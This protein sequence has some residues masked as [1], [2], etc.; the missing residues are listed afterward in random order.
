MLRVHQQRREGLLRMN[1][2]DL[3]TVRRLEADTESPSFVR[4]LV[5]TYERMLSPRVER[6][7]DAV[8]ASDAEQALDAALSLRVSSIMIGTTEL[9]DLSTAVLADLKNSDLPSARAQALLLPPAA[10]RARTAIAEFLAGGS[11]APSTQTS[12]DSIR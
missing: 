6:L 1:A 11:S 2:F 9:V 12:T 10:E 3:S 7:V 8:L 5:E 4:E